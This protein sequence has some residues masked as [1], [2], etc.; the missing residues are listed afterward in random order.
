MPLDL[1]DGTACFVDSNILYYALVPPAEPSRECAGLLDRAIA[2]RVS[3]HVSVPILSDAVH[4]VM[5]VEAAQL[6]GRDR[7]GIVSYLKRHPDVISRLTEY[8]K[9]MATLSSV[10][11]TLFPVDEH[12]LAEAT[13]IAVRHGLL[14][15][16]SMIVALMQRH[17]LTHLV[18]N[19]DDFDRVPG[20]SIW[21]P[22]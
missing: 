6:L 2:N 17:G 8:P 19:D 20:L 7:A 3:L 11:M 4:K 18:T 14:T 12:L 22:R 15:N 16:D 21:K 10:P 13:K 1:P 9:A 5:T